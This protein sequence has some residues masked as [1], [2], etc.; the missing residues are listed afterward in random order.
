MKRLKSSELDF[1]VKDFVIPEYPRPVDEHR[2]LVYNADKDSIKHMMF[3]EI[4]D[5]LERG[6]LLVFNNSRVLNT[7]V[8]LDNNRFILF[9]E[10]FKNSL[11][12]VRVIC[13]FKP[14]VG[15]T[16]TVG[17]SQIEL[18]SH[19]VGWDVYHANII[20]EENY[21]TLGNFLDKY[22]KI[23]MPIYLKR[24]PSG[25]DHLALQNFYSK[26]L[27]SIATPVAGLHFD[28]EL[29]EDLKKN[30]IETTEVTLH[31]GYGTF[32]SFKTEFIDQHIM[33][34]ETYYLNSNAVS[35][36]KNAKEDGKKI[37]AVGTTSARV[38]ESIA[39]KEYFKNPSSAQPIF[40]DTSIFIYPP[41]D[42]QLVDGLITNFQYPRLPVLTMAAALTGLEKL[43]KVYDESIAQK[44]SYYTFGDAMILLK[45]RSEK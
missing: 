3:R 18:I 40:D 4:T 44:Y 28:K 5:I 21:K 17:K 20:S 34:K 8:Y 11:D 36:I 15:Q 7:S 6:D 39:S 35:K 25:N 38:L 27:G 1:L 30:G 41:Y 43:K 33:D 9:I 12:D 29:L 22:A 19:E 10:P 23:P 24:I 37:I 26:P 16:F 32:R 31:V 45:N 2:L 14:D 42:F 13:P